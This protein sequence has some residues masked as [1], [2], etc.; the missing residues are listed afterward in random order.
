M[1]VKTVS[2]TKDGIVLKV[3]GASSVLVNSIR[4]AALTRVPVMAVEEVDMI[5]NTSAMYDEL[6]AHR[7]GLVALSFNPKRHKPPAECRCKGKGCA[8]CTVK[9]VLEKRGPGN[10]YASDL[11]STDEDVK[12]LHPRAVLLLLRAN[13]E[14]KLEASAVMSTG[15]DHAKHLPAVIGY[16]FAAKKLKGE[17]VAD[18][19][20]ITL[21]VESISGLS[22]KDVLLDASAR[23]RAELDELRKEVTS[24]VK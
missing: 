16:S 23:L 15:R 3:E 19:A 7:L 10:V 2:K 4:R 22:P 12:P 18:E 6:F 11:K 24:K 5:M 9:L 20:S 1:K 17:E 14:V 21:K 13:Q 8:K